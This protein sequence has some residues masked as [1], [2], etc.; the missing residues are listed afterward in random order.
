MACD[1]GID[2]FRT[3]GVELTDGQICISVNT[4]HFFIDGFRTSGVELS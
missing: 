1:F 3:S 4:C 2:G